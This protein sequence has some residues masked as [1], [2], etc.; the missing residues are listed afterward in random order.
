MV[1]ARIVERSFCILG[2]ARAACDPLQVVVE[3]QRT[4]VRGTTQ[5]ERTCFI[6]TR[7]RRD[8]T[9]LHIAFDFSD[10][11]EFTL[12][13]NSVTLTGKAVI[14]RGQARIHYPARRHL[15]VRQGSRFR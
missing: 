12:T 14:R 2:M 6:V 8:Q 3:I 13:F 7:S 4:T 1:A 15:A 11:R 5:V 10:A 9:P